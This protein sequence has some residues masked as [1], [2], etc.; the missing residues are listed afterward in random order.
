MMIKNLEAKVHDEERKKKDLEGYYNQKRKNWEKERKAEYERI[1]PVYEQIY[2]RLGLPS[3][4]IKRTSEEVFIPGDGSGKGFLT[5]VK[6]TNRRM[7]FYV[8]RSGGIYKERESHTEKTKEV[9]FRGVKLNLVPIE[10]LVNPSTSQWSDYGIRSIG[11][12]A[13]SL[14]RIGERAKYEIRYN[15]GEVEYRNVIGGVP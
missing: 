10:T 1:K 15:D 4:P 3:Q 8:L 2:A 7:V 9:R 5:K 13:S 6:L 11:S 14:L 12:I